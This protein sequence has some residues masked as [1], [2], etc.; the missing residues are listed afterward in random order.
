MSVD[1]LDSIRFR[2]CTWVSTW[3][4]AF[5]HPVLGN[6]IGSFRIL[7][8]GYRRPQIFYIEGKHNTET[9]HAE[10]EYCEVLQDEGIVGFGILIWF[11]VTFS[12]QRWRT[13]R[14]TT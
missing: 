7:Y 11:I 1:R 4:M 9:D 13:H 6:G 3:E 8:P 10:D 14:R 5:T 2:I 12:V